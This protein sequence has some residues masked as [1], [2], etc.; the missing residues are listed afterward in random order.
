M[1]HTHSSWELTTVLLSI[2][3]TTISSYLGVPNQSA[4]KLLSIN[5]QWNVDI[6][7]G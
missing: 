6:A 2:L 1:P 5:S 4:S 7:N 3:G